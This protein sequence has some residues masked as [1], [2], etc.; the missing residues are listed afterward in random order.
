MKGLRFATRC[1]SLEQFVAMFQRHCDA[2][3]VFV[4]TPATRPVGLETA[5]SI[6]LADGKPALRGMGVVIDSW[7]TPSNRFG[8]PGIQFGIRKLTADSEK[9][10]EQ[11]LVARAIT[12][13]RERAAAP[14]APADAANT[15]VTEPPAV[16]PTA[17][18]ATATDDARTPGG[19]LVLPANP[20][21]GIADESLEGFVDCTIYE[22]TGNFFP[23]EPP[24]ED[25]QDPPVAPPLLAPMPR[26]N[27]PM[28]MAVP[29]VPAP[30]EEAQRR[31]SE[32]AL[33]LAPEDL[34]SE[35]AI[36]PPPIPAMPMPL[37]APLPPTPMPV[38]AYPSVPPPTFAP[39]LHKPALVRARESW[40]NLVRDPRRRWLVIAVAALPLVVIVLVAALARSGSSS[41][42]GPAD[43]TPTPAPAKVVHATAAPA[44]SPATTPAHAIVDPPP[45]ETAAAAGVPTVGAGPCK[46]TVTSTPAGSIVEIDG[47]RA[48]PSPLT[49]AGPCQKRQ[50]AISH[51]RYETGQRTVTPTTDKPAQAVDVTLQRP[52]HHLMIE[53]TPSGATISIGGHRAGTSPTN[54]EVMGFTGID[55][56]IAKPPFYR[57][58]TKHVYSKVPNDRLTVTLLH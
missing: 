1:A 46:I 56:T 31:M 23:V 20:L 43:P 33:E 28:P 25:L 29:V 27:T 19:D 41:A 10:F 32:P 40:A 8:R 15:D 51:P 44:T 47:E 14:V 3:S 18:T 21:S 55:I 57:P 16:P 58:I 13:D 22:E 52:M 53:T 6:D 30:V 35:P 38:P 17:A 54:V 39:V 11:L 12:A 9:V 4:P 7:S 36:R 5:F 42:A 26:R 50:L 37:V 48:G 49:I 24:P 34:V 2:Q 45:D